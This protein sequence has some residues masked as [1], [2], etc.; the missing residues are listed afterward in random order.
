MIKCFEYL[1]LT[2][3][4]PKKIPYIYHQHELGSPS[5]SNVFISSSKSNNKRMQI[6]RSKDGVVFAT[7]HA[8]QVQTH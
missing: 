7:T 8:H 6:G 1:K 3:Y 5:L 2:R 4:F